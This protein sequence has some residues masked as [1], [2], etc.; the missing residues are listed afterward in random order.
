MKKYE[1]LFFDLDRTL[2]D[3]EKNS[4]ETLVELHYAHLK[5]SGIELQQ[6][7]TV[8]KQINTAMWKEYAEG[9]IDKNYL[10]TQRFYNT[11]NHF[12]LPDD[13]L[14]DQ[15]G[16]AYVEICPKKGTCFPE[17]HE[18]LDYLRGK[19]VL[20]IITNGFEE[21][22]E[23]KLKHSKLDHYFIEVITSEMAG[24]KKP[25]PLIFQ[26]ALDRT[27]AQKGHSL[28]VGDDH[29]ADIQGAETFGMD[30]LHFNPHHPKDTDTV[31]REFRILRE[32][33]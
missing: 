3:F 26:T 13:R 15:I 14:A 33:L 2:W 20:H 1:H 6:F 5:N 16:E 30:A 32:R 7:I 22:Q 25:D 31:I 8:Y 28:M 21:V 29:H 9:L 11:L 19:Y 23:V 4:E 10:R 27:G 17:V 24:V 18:T 12:G